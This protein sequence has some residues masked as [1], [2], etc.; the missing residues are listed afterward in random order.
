MPKSY[1][2]IKAGWKNPNATENGINRQS[3]SYKEIKAS[4]YDFGVNNDYIK[5]FANESQ[6]LFKNINKDIE[7]INYNNV[8]AKYKQKQNELKDIRNK[9]DTIRAY[10]NANKKNIDSDS[11]NSTIKYL[12]ELDSSS[13]NLL[14]GYRNSVDF[15]KQFSNESEYNEWKAY[16]KYKNIDLSDRKKI[17]EYRKSAETEEEKNYL[18]WKGLETYSEDE[19]KQREE[20]LKLANDYESAQNIHTTYV[21]KK[22]ERLSNTPLSVNGTETNAYQLLEDAY[23]LENEAYAQYAELENLGKAHAGHTTEEFKQKQK[24][25][26]ETQEKLNT[27][28]KV[29]EEN[30][31]KEEKDALAVI[32]GDYTRKGI[33]SFSDRIG[34]AG[35]FL[36]DSYLTATGNYQRAESALRDAHND[37]LDY[38]P[39][40]D[41]VLDYLGVGSNNPISAFHKQTKAQL[42]YETTI[43]EENAKA[44]NLDTKYGEIWSGAVSEL[45]NAAFSFA[46]GALNNAA[47]KG[48]DLVASSAYN[49]SSVLGKA[50]ITM[51]NML[52][53]PQY[54]TSFF[55]EVGS[56]YEEALENGANRDVAVITAT[57]TSLINSVIEIG[58]DG[59]SGIQGLPQE[60]LSG[61]KSV[62]ASWAESM[63]EEGKEEVLQGIV[64]N[65]V[66]KVSY[67]HDK[68]LVG[69]NGEAV[70]DPYRAL[71]EFGMG[72]AVG[73]ILGGG[74][75][76][77]TAALSGGINA[78]GNSELR[79]YG[80]NIRKTEGAAEQL[81][82][83][84]QAHP[85]YKATANILSKINTDNVS[86]V[87]LGKVYASVWSDVENTVKSLKSDSEKAQ[88]LEALYINNGN[89]PIIASAAVGIATNLDNQKA[90]RTKAAS[91]KYAE[92]SHAVRNAVFS[93]KATDSDIKNI[94]LDNDTIEEFEDI[95]GKKIQGKTTAEQESIVRDFLETR[96]IARLPYKENAN[97]AV[98]NF[99]TGEDVVIRGIK[100]KSNSEVIF[101]TS[102]GD[103]SYGDISMPSSLA[104]VIK[105]ATSKYGIDTAN[106]F[107]RHL[108]DTDMN[109][110][111][112]AANFS[113]IYN[114]G[115]ATDTSFEEVSKEF[116]SA[117]KNMGESAAR[118]AF[119]R[120]RA[121]I[122]KQKQETPN[123]TTETRS[124]YTNESDIEAPFSPEVYES[125]A[126]K[127]GIDIHRIEE[128]SPVRGHFNV[129]MMSMLINADNSNEFSTLVHELGE[130]GEALNYEGMKQ[131]QDNVI[132]WYL[133]QNENGISLD[134][135]IKQYQAAY[136]QKTK[137][138]VSYE[139][140]VKEITNDAIAGLF[141]TDGGIKQ[142]V[143]WVH[144][145]SGLSVPE[146][147]TLLQ[148]IKDILNAI[149]LKLR[150][151]VKGKDFT[152]SESML[153]EMEANEAAKLR[154]QFL[155]A[156]DEATANL[157]TIKNTDTENVSADVDYSINVDYVNQLDEWNKNG[158]DSEDSFTLGSTGNVL[159]GLGAIESDIFIRGEKINKILADHK[160]ITLDEIK[161]IPEMLEDPVLIAKSQ[162]A[163]RGSKQNTRLL[164]YGSVNAKDGRPAMVVFDLRP[165]ENNF[166]IDDMQKV[167]SMY[168]KDNAENLLSKSEVLYA[169]KK[170][171][172][173]LLRSI[174]FQMPIELQNSGYI[175][176]ISYNGRNVNTSGKNFSEVF[177]IGGNTE[178]NNVLDRVSSGIE[179]SIAV[180]DTKTLDFLNEQ[181][182]NGEV[183][184]VYR[185]MAVDENGRLYPP[186]AGN[187]R[188]NGKK[189]INGQASDFNVWEQSEESI[190]WA[191][192]DEKFLLEKGFEK[193]S[194]GK[195]EKDSVIFYQDKQGKWKA[196]FHLDK[197]N[198]SVVDAA[199]AP[200][201]HTSLSM[202]NDQFTSAYT[203]NN[204][205]VVRGYV[206][207]SEIYGDNLYKANFAEK[208]VGKTKWHSGV[209][210]AQMPETRTVILSRYFM[211]IEIVDDS[212][213]A[214]SVKQM[215]KG[216]DIEIP[217]N[218]VTPSQRKALEAIGV[219][220]GEARGL[221][222]APKK[223]DIRF[224][225]KL[226]VEET[227]DLIA[228]HNLTQEELLK[229][230]K[231]GGFPMPSVAIVKAKNGHN[232]FGDV[233]VIFDK[234]TIDPSKSGNKVYG[235]DVLTPTFPDVN[236]EINL[237]NA[238]KTML[239][240]ESKN[241]GMF[242][243]SGV[244]AAA[245]KRY[246]SISEIKE[247]SSRLKNLSQK[248]FETIRDGFGKRLNEIADSITDTKIKNP[249]IARQSA[250]SQIVDAINTSRTKSG[251]LRA[252]Q[253]YNPKATEMT[254]QDIIDLV[255]DISNMPT[256]Y[257]EAKPRRA[258]GL[259]EIKAIL[260]PSNAG[261]DLK[262]ALS[263]YNTVEYKAGNAEDRIAKLNSLSNLKFSLAVDSKKKSSYNE[264]ETNAM[265]WA[266]ATERTD[267]DK[268]F[269][270][271]PKTDEWCLIVAGR[272]YDGGYG[273]LNYFKDYDNAYN[274]VKEYT[275]GSGQEF[276]DVSNRFTD[277]QNGDNSSRYGRNTDGV[278][279][280]GKN[281]ETQRLVGREPERGG[282][283]DTQRGGSNSDGRNVNYSISVD[284]VSDSRADIVLN[285]K[286]QKLVEDL[287]R[288]YQYAKEEIYKTKGKKIDRV[289]V[290]S[291]IKDIARFYNSKIDVETFTDRLTDIYNR[292]AKDKNLTPDSYKYEIEALARD[293]IDESKRF[294]EVSE[295]SKKIL[296]D[297]KV[298]AI[299]FSEA[300]QKEAAYIA[301]SFKNYRNNLMG[302]VIIATKDTYAMDVNSWAEQMISKYPELRM[303][304]P[305]G[306]IT[307]GDVVAALPDIIDSLRNTYQA[308]MEGLDYESEVEMTTLELLDSFAEMPRR[309]T[310]ADKK[311]SELKQRIKE[312]R[313]EEKEK[314]EKRVEKV[315]EKERAAKKESK[316]KVYD[317]K[318]EQLA[319]Q[320]AFYQERAKRN[321]E[322]RRESDERKRLV[323]R[324]YKNVKKMTEMLNKPTNNA[325]IPEVLR[326]TVG[327]VLSQI[328]LLENGRDYST[329]SV[330]DKTLYTELEKMKS[331]I[332]SI[333]KAQMGE[334]DKDGN[335]D[336]DKSDFELDLPDGFS[337]E[338]DNLAKRVQ[339]YIQQ[340]E[341]FTLH[342]MSNE[343]LA[344]LDY[345]LTIMK[346]S[347]SQ[348]NRMYENARYSHIE[349]LGNTTINDIT[350]Y[351]NQKKFTDNA[352]G[353]FL[354]WKNA[355][356]VYAF[357]RF[358]EAGKSVFKEIAN[359]WSKLARNAQSV[360]DFS[361]KTWTP[362]EYN[363]W[364]EE[365]HE[366]KLHDGKTVKM[367]TPQ[368]M[369]LYLLNQREQARKH[370][371]GGGVV[372]ID[373]GKGKNGVT[374]N[375]TI[376]DV[377]K[378]TSKLSKRQIEVA[379]AIQNQMSTNGSDWGNEIS[380]TRFGYKFFTEPHYFPISVDEN[381]KNILQS[382]SMKSTDIFRLLNMG[383][384]K[385]VNEKANAPIDVFD[386][387]DVF[388]DH[389]S[390]MAKYNALALPILDTIKWINYKTRIPLSEGGFKM[391]SVREAMD[392]AYGKDAQKYVIRFLKD[393]NG[394]KEGGSD[395]DSFAGRM[396]SNV[397]VAKVGANL[398]VALLQPT[399]YARA[400]YVLSAKSLAMGLNAAV[401]DGKKLYQEALNKSGLALWKDQGFYDTNINRSMR[402]MIKND[403]GIIDTIK[404]KSMILAEAGD[405]ATWTA[406]WGACRWEVLHQNPDIK[407][408]SQEFYTKV[409]DLFDET[410]LKTQVMDSTITRSELMRDSS[411]A[412]KTI[413]AFGSESAVSYNM[414]MNGLSEFSRL[415][416]Q[417]ASKAVLLQSLKHSSRA[418]VSYI[419]TNAISA[420]A[421]SLFDWERDEDKDEKFGKTWWD[422]FVLN[423]STLLK[424]PLVKEVVGQLYANYLGLGYSSS[425]ETQSEI[426]DDIMA[427]AR[428][429]QKIYKSVTSGKEEISPYGVAYILGNL[430]SDVTGIPITP[431]MREAVS[432][433]NTAVSSMGKD[434]WIIRKSPVT[435]STRV[436]NAVNKGY[437]YFASHIKDI[438]EYKKTE[439]Y[440]NLLGK[441]F[442]EDY[443]RR[444][445]TDEDAKKSI[446]STLTSIFK[447]EYVTAS[448]SRRSEIERMMRAS[449]VYDDV[450]KTVNDWL[451][452]YAETEKYKR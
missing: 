109:P 282:T 213:M 31:L 80:E 379:N 244:W 125:V 134:N 208:S 285:E 389:M 53:N 111:Q 256:E 391:E 40:R 12:N 340:D 367:N 60:L 113:A 2:S 234:N 365:V 450:S 371:Y 311:E 281:A 338:V 203:R 347:V 106:S 327:G 175:G 290:K 441:D 20:E 342:T 280:N 97:I 18:Y 413:T 435:A 332:A 182:K 243:V 24:E 443:A 357:E 47:Q 128:E 88:Y 13:E 186:M 70:I 191:S 302:S 390:D 19:L 104:T 163:G 262:T 192:V 348:I 448:F 100:K 266:N 432:A 296:R 124:R 265:Q 81:I 268:R 267:G 22:K 307:S 238:V 318:N 55:E 79:K 110:A 400:G 398:R 207:N 406:L 91:K 312:V 325:H 301:D 364:K 77:G 89:S 107:L 354:K 288:K 217:Y 287:K 295:H 419:L 320:K 30:N 41:E 227:K 292:M 304:F 223:D 246:N 431:A 169:D 44:A 259:D 375:M 220:I 76:L 388:A 257:F 86:D 425:S 451:N 136:E 362:K 27:L 397:K 3:K 82:Q 361:E 222:N 10:F 452:K 63:L 263:D 366:V 427:V 404:E 93:E 330:R 329:L 403:A 350:S 418:L 43:A 412:A 393:L 436:R 383:A 429:V 214:Q 116:P 433:Y 314:F 119:N 249:L 293:I 294:T 183:T 305:D 54:W 95:T 152:G 226:P 326:T 300:D 230:L 439:M 129:N 277:R 374:T 102:A 105:D 178:V 21:N 319:R 316:Q 164:I 23:N 344:S 345:I 328:E 158:R 189:K 231:L 258:V 83:F 202:L 50:G 188:E 401:R 122:V 33:T 349:E 48:A 358:G 343:D 147:K 310:F 382:N 112:Y 38:T 253:Q 242:S 252:L 385:G 114:I 414:L 118:A 161:K 155:K 195:F 274:Y 229:T 69:V 66:A 434:E 270:Y 98:R 57:I 146:Q 108:T 138:S 353:G 11:Y 145:D 346:H 276:S 180:T 144:T 141:N 428:A 420:L 17:A 321:A 336:Y 92:K 424:I 378:I 411:F 78:L 123:V 241:N 209:V 417:G 309:Q 216:K 337:N 306:T 245:A 232:E 272:E 8:S 156:I 103:M 177:S 32:F 339:A 240:E 132:K 131:V 16:D 449:G 68:P 204:L 29:I 254:V 298:N 42:G 430:A 25:Y 121:D 39:T 153:L 184:E 273:V 352:A 135:Y 206:P 323:P 196:K 423:N 200:Y 187:V 377:V 444:N 35:D 62:I 236:Y 438:I 56:N 381:A 233:S 221:Q 45:P 179:Y 130:Y 396:L 7:D 247:D 72:A 49:N 67:D 408:N 297:I 160:E 181:L 370:I 90:E 167:N 447:A 313:A 445:S 283:A 212:V 127:T 46:Y 37:D 250:M 5:T 205:V 317:K 190:P 159:Q 384:T 215:M 299:Y 143:M 59:M 173:K 372:F 279:D 237:E 360:I 36:I 426:G 399:S 96:D 172:T 421:E 137:S 94:L 224:S 373:G 407:L 52:K 334:T 126:K 34:A 165:V 185:A 442:T 440:Y 193:K 392:T 376:D 115:R 228:V 341:H 199:Y 75:I 359:G 61:N 142:F 356:P 284:N 198:G 15:M 197:D 260:I 210:A 211:P 101:E 395:F 65:L 225:L 51:R 219:R 286:Y 157:Q 171:A 176:S 151:W 291:T 251:M 166:V 386:A 275:N 446:R 405:K 120:G 278:R 402:S 368:I 235:G 331:K 9:A 133:K 140:A 355:T 322:A 308:D 303:F 410:I 149:A 71:E 150:E 239:S 387:F 4:D 170:R 415:K 394:V 85:E 14:K 289:A 84:A 369:S 64:Q 73:G 409:T 58:T 351:G 28:N 194:N 255:N 363:A 117:V 74:Q 87:Q 416:G 174:G 333:E 437:D 218:V 148:K 380:M 264:F 139:E 1:N 422:N 168:V 6:G 201:I 324:I 26:T 248:E 154:S 261:E 162:N 271:N 99:D 269:L 335:I 315:I